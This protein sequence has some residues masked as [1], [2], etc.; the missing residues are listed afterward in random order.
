MK[1]LERDHF[2]DF[3]SISG[4]K[5]NPSKT[6][7]AYAL[8]NTRL[9]QNDYVFTLYAYDGSRS[10]R[11]LNLKNES[12]FFWE[13]DTVL[14]IPFAKTA[15]DKAK[16]KAKYTVLYRYDLTTKQLTY[17]TALPIPI[18]ALRVLSEQE[19][20]ISA[21]LS[22]EAHQLFDPK[23]RDSFLAE[24]KEFTFVETFD[25]IPFYSNG[26]GFLKGARSQC[27]VYHPASERFDSIVDANFSVDTYDYDDENQVI[28]YA[29][30]EIKGV[31][32]LKSR[33]FAYD[34]KTKKT[35]VLVD[36]LFGYSTIKK[37][38]NRLIVSGSNQEEF[39][40]NQNP[41]FYAVEEGRLVL[42][43][44]FGFPDHS[45][46]GSDT[47]LGGSPASLKHAT[48][49][50]FIGLNNYSSNLIEINEQGE[51]S[52]LFVAD[53]AS[54]DGI[55]EINGSL[56]AIILLD[57]NLQEIY[58]L[59]LENNGY[60]QITAVNQSVLQDYYVGG[61]EYI[62]YTN[63]HVQLDGWVIK[64]R[65]YD[66]A[67]KY[68]AI[69][70]IHGGPKTVYSEVYYHEMQV[71]AN[72]GYFVF[73]TNPRGGDGRFGD[74][75]DIRGKYGTIDYD[76]LMVFTDTVLNSYP[77]IDKDRVGVT[78]GSYGGF[79][80]NWIVGHTDRFKAAA[81]QRSISNWIS[82]YGTSDIGWYFAS[83]QNDGTL[84]A[85]LEKLWFHSPLKYVDQVKTPLLFV[86]SDEDYRCPIEQGLQFYTL[87]K[88]RGVETSFVWFKGEN[89]ELSRSGKPKARLKRLNAITDWMNNHLK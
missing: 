18:T 4:L 45:S 87:L 59:D 7:F 69:L 46:I 12:R 10:W 24:Q 55:V 27:F 39:G 19:W 58:E 81:T 13:S 40:L 71:W 80:T 8:S 79:M 3:H 37:L 88:E 20:L 82:F 49:F 6:V 17:A 68:P 34:L 67:K 72:E 48:D 78:G 36:E 1:K 83:D 42:I 61:I 16:V 41:D 63:D 26:S 30:N 35:T 60:R 66:P 21:T 50:W 2:L 52:E 47:R 86:H 77:A 85:D 62:D 84:M 53:G 33:L 5:A 29:G 76:D 56:Y 54:I 38:K 75:S 32:P 28:Y 31:M 23:K 73:F 43:A 70:D 14:L 74:F 15:A 44:E 65:N 9:K 89:H 25:E 51:L 57:Q 64:P 11:L 22:K